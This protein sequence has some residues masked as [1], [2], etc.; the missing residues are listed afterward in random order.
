MPTPLMINPQTTLFLLGFYLAPMAHSAVTAMPDLN[1]TS[2]TFMV[3]PKIVIH[4]FYP[5]PI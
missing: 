3:F 4:P 2:S 1:R 5:I